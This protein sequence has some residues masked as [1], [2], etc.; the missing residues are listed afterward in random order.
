MSVNQISIKFPIASIS[1]NH[2]LGFLQL[3]RLLGDPSEK[4]PSL[5]MQFSVDE[6]S[7]KLMLRKESDFVRGLCAV[8]YVECYIHSILYAQV[9]RKHIMG[10]RNDWK[11]IS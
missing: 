2:L 8:S 3:C 1:K 7:M 11:R 4:H 6:Y 5:L 9:A 10:D